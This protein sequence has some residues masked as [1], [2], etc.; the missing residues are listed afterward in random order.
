[1]NQNL[2]NVLA[3]P[4]WWERFNGQSGKITGVT[5]A[6]TNVPVIH[7]AVNLIADALATAPV[8]IYRS[9]GETETAWPFLSEPS[10]LLRE[11]AQSLL[12]HGAAFWMINP[13]A[14]TGKPRDVQILKAS[15]VKVEYENG[16]LSFTYQ[17]KP[18]APEQ[19][20]YFHEYNPDND[21]LPGVSCTRVALADA[22]LIGYLTELA[23]AFFEGGAMPV[24]LLGVPV[25]T[26]QADLERTE[27]YFKNLMTGVKRA[28]RV[29]AV[30]S[31]AIVPTVL[32]P[33]FKDMIMPELS[34]EAR[35]A[36]SH[37]FG[38]PITMLTDAANYATATEHRLSFWQD[39]VKPFGERIEAAI[40]EQLLARLGLRLELA[41]D[42]LDVFQ[43]DEG[44]RAVRL[45][46]LTG[47][48]VPLWLAAQEAG[49]NPEFVEELKAAEAEKQRRAD[50]MAAQ[51]QQTPVVENQTEETPA[52]A[53]VRRWMTKAT[54][55]VKRGETASVPFES[56]IIPEDDQQ[57]IRAALDDAKTVEEVR[58]AFF[59]AGKAASRDRREPN[60]RKKLETEAELTRL[61]TRRFARQARSIREQLQREYPNR[62]TTLDYDLV[63]DDGINDILMV[64]LDALK[65][66][67][68]MFG[69]RIGL[70]LDFT[71]INA[72]ALERARAYAYDL[73]R[74]ID[75]TTRE[76][77]QRVIS[78]FVQTPGMTIGDVMDLLP[79]DERR[80]MRI[81]VTETTR[82]YAEGNRMGA[83]KL[84]EDFPGVRVVRQWYTNNDDLVCPVCGG[85]DGKEV[86]GDADFAPG[87]A[88]PP[89]HPN[90]RCWTD[91]RT[92]IEVDE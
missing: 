1:M 45:Q 12:I 88:D 11:T 70:A 89:A 73:V 46:T 51:M 62:K 10:A 75:D 72:N 47:A 67:A 53:E 2:K 31:G 30:R 60:R 35:L 18:Y 80:A 55:A 44:E 83:E 41:Y 48:G 28:F 8:K 82:A 77:L 49:Y 13:G 9:K 76:I 27:G 59:F 40:N 26:S 39:T 61:L 87:I 66:G 32:T 22:R 68:E 21:I 92:R 33:P 37:A 34:E 64:I 78:T 25:G 14:V 23:G 17:Q 69:E 85:L 65:T 38:I 84:K 20:V 74:G 29:L 90:C 15:A 71:G 6:Y 52:Q 16:V 5:A 24:T 54:R 7:R 81:A 79:F 36:V 42:E 63:E 4:E 3:N 50:E 57:R 19:I 58:A 56:E 43:E 91:Y 86:E